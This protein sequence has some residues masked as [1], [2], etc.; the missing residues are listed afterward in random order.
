MP[1]DGTNLA[2]NNLFKVFIETFKSLHLGA[3]EGHCVRV[4]LSRDIQI[5]N[6]CFNP[7]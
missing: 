3:G 7:G 2:D 4:L 5:R 1:L 6:V